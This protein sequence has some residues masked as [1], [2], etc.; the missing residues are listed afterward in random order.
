MIYDPY[1]TDQYEDEDKCPADCPNN[2]ET[3]CPY[4]NDGKGHCPKEEDGE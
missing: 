4:Q 2:T 3:L 1:D